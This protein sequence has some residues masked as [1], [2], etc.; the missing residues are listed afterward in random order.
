[1][2][3]IKPEFDKRNVQI[4]IIGLSVGPVETADIKQG[5]AQDYPMIGD[6]DVGSN[7]SDGVDHFGAR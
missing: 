4:I 6:A 1:M 7:P 3:Q 2:A 5:V